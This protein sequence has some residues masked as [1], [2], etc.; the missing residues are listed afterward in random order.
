MDKTEILEIL[1]EWNYWNR[2]KPSGIERE[3]YKNTIGSFANS[4]EIIVIKGVRRSGKSTLMLNRIKRLMG[5]GIDAKEILFV[6]L[7]DPRFINHLSTKL[8][9]QIKEVYIEYLDPLNKPYIFLDEIQNIPYW[10]K[11][12]NKE[13]ELK[14]SHLMISGSNSSMLNSEIASV[15]SGRYLAID[16]YPLSFKEFLD[17]KNINLANKLDMI[18]HKI[19]INRVFEEYLKYGGFPKVTLNSEQK[20]DLLISYKDTILLRDIVKRYKLKEFSK[21]EEIA[22]FLL[23]NSGISTSINKV[24]NNFS[25]SYDMAS[26]YI[27]YLVKAYMLFEI[28]KF[29]YSLKGKQPMIKNIT[30]LI[31]VLVTFLEYQA[32][33]QE[34]MTW[35]P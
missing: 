33:K 17:F 22:S 3:L 18:D 13:Y 30:A 21:L 27:E 20:K 34:A 12:L 28:N 16:V 1:N 11:W 35:K 19:E 6:N 8:L 26:A 31:W 23:S 15:L 5:N 9:Q 4:G 32:C 2:K 24:K 7:E 25:I 10:E 14:L 29:D